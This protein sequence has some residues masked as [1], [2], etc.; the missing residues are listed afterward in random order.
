M[1]NVVGIYVHADSYD[2]EFYYNN[3]MD[4]TQ[5]DAYDENENI[6]DDG[7]HGNHYSDYTGVDEDGD[8]IGDTPYNISGGNNQDL[9]PKMMPYPNQAPIAEFT[10][11]PLIPIVGEPV[12]FDSSASYDP[13]DT[14]AS[15]YWT[16]G[17]GE[18]STDP[19]PVHVYDDA[20]IYVV[21]LEVTDHWDATSTIAYP[22]T[23]SDNYPPVAD[24]GPD[25][26]VNTLEVNFDGSNSYDPDGYI[27]TYVWDF[28]DDTTGVGEVTSHTY[29]DDGTYAVVLT[30]TDNG[31]LSDT[32]SALVIVDTIAPNTMGFHTGTMGDNDWYV[33]DVLVMLFAEDGTGSGVEETYYR[34]NGGSWETYEEPFT[35][36]DDGEYT[37]EYYSVDY[38][39][40]EEEVSEPMEFKIDSEAPTIELT[41][42]HQGGNTWL[43]TA[44]VDDETSGVAQV[45]FYVDDV[46]VAVVTSEPWEYE[47]TGSGEE[48]QAVVYDNAG[49]SAASEKVQSSSFQQDT[50]MVTQ[51]GLQHFTR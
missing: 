33:S 25:Q 23:I 43:F 40:N 48:A 18:T 32:D 8:G 30:V 31:G 9:Y 37:V 28:G 26:I 27:T 51:K 17:D 20:G 19:N 3:L 22:I 29:T 34:I 38:A 21:V 11:I 4:N 10:W 35:V 14:I 44:E 50:S 15:W 36:T 47:Y 7:E 6:W 24:A 49:N 39:G 41:A 16:F 46:L 45:E 2:N 5:C 1:N 42:E 12:L 13:D